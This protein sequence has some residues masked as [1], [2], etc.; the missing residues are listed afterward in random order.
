MSAIAGLYR[1]DGEPVSRHEVER[2]SSRS[3]TVARTEPAR[4]VAARPRSPTERCGRPRR[5]VRSRSPWP[6]PPAT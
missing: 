5:R 4:G 6:A 3:R 1:M 2:R